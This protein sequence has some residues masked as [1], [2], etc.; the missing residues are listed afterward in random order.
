MTHAARL[1]RLAWAE[2]SELASS[3]AAHLDLVLEAV[4]LAVLIGVPLGVLATR[5]RTFERIALGL[6]NALQTVPSLALL[7]F[8]LILLGTIGKPPALA[9]LVIYALLPILKNTVVGLRGIDPSVIEAATGMGMTARQRLVLVELPLAVPVVLGGVRVAAVAA[10]GMATIA[11]AIGARGLGSYIF[12]GVQLVDTD[13]IL[14]GAIPAAILALACDAALGEVERGWDYRRARRSRARLVLGA[15][16]IVALLGI[17]LLGWVGDLARGSKNDQIVVGSKDSAEQRVLA[18]LIAELIEAETDLDVDLRDGLGGTL[19]CYEAL[20]SPGGG[21]DVYV[22]YTGTA[23]TAIHKQPPRNDPKAVLETVRRECEGDGV[24][25]LDPLGFENT[26]AL[27]MRRDLSERLSVRSISDLRRHLGTLRIGFGPEFGRRP[28]GFPGV[29]SAYGLS[30]TNRPREMDRNL[31]YEAV[32]QGSIDVGVGDST[33]G[34]IATLGLIVLRDDRRFFPPYEAVPL[35]RLTA[36]EGHPELRQV[37]GLLVGRI[38]TATMQRLNA[39]VDG[40]HRDPKEVAREFLEQLL[41][42]PVEP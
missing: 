37:L 6:A 21:L 23:L 12:S 38:D 24:A 17:A 31:L 3:A 30:F 33:D 9:A 18:A 13:R 20:R 42:N 28:D 8:L 27:V 32:A 39:E 7:G 19:L 22:E 34:R 14:L 5:S 29:S 16:G 40:K 35:V 2:R 10:V 15:V 4:A 1:L 26:F 11:A 41:P 36:L 25:C